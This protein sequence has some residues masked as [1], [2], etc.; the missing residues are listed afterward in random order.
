MKQTIGTHTFSSLGLAA[1]LAGGCV[2][3]QTQTSYQPYQEPIEDQETDEVADPAGEDQAMAG[4]DDGDESE[5]AASSKGRRVQFN[6]RALDRT[7]WAIVMQIERATNQRLPDGAYWYDPMCGAA[8]VWGGPALAFLPAGLPLGGSR[9][10]PSASGGGRG[11]LTG[12]FIN[13]RELHPRDVQV[14]TVIYGQPPQPGRYWVDGYGNAGYE[15]GPALVNLV[16]L[17]NQRWAGR[18]GGGGGWYQRT[19]GVGGD[20][21]GGS[22]GQTHYFFDSA[23]G[24]SVMNDG[25]G[26]SC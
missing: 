23:S 10:P 24:C 7:G 22:D 2:P 12:V 9:V 17:A 14:L 21:Y 19:W 3:S 4:P 26:V 11:R 1:C 15:G 8:G 5:S 25:G 20:M 18:S 6:G 13:G 16:Q